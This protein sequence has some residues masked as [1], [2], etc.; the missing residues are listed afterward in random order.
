[1]P[2]RYATEEIDKLKICILGQSGMGKTRMAIATLPP[3]AKVLILATEPGL[4]SVRNELRERPTFLPYKIKSLPE[5]ITVLDHFEGKSKKPDY[6]VVDSLTALASLIHRNCKSL[7]K[8][9]DMWTQFNDKFDVTLDRLLNFPKSNMICTAIDDLETDKSGEVSRLPLIAGGKMKKFMLQ[10]FDGTFFL[11]YVTSEDGA[12]KSILAVTQH[13]DDMPAKNRTGTLDLHEP[14]DL[15][16]I[17]T[18]MLGFLPGGE[19]Q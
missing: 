6:V 1:M 7:Y 16:H 8:H 19:S 5:F 3:K 10:N 17:I 13:L 15:S 4:M 11:K 2:E 14:P 12:T 9:M 18:K